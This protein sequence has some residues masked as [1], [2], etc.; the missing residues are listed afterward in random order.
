M[1]YFNF[2][3]SDNRDSAR[4]II[5]VQQKTKRKANSK[6]LKNILISVFLSD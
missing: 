5:Q 4:C 1:Q 2:I 6:K 3:D